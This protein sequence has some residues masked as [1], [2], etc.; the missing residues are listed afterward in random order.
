MT[1]SLYNDEKQ[2]GKYESL[3]TKTI[4]WANEKG[5]LQ[6][7]TPLAQ[8]KKTLEE[9][10]ELI[11]ALEAQEKG[12][13]SFVNSKGKTVNTKDEIKDALG[14]IEVTIQIG[15]KLQNLELIDCFESAYNVIKNR[16]GKIIN[17]VFV[18]EADL[19]NS[20]K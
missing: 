6:K 10:H 4:E 19:N 17:G 9:V 5:I 14:D 12:V 3:S 20:T 7:A 15:A 11:E 13:E 2:L 8:A 1:T 18:K 16:K